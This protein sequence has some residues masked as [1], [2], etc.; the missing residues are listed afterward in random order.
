M[1]KKLAF[2]AGVLFL[3]PLISFAAQTYYDSIVGCGIQTIPQFIKALLSI[4]IKI[5][6]PIASVFLIWTGF[7]FLTAQGDESKLTKAKSA[8]F[9][10]CIGFGVVIGA[11]LIS[12]VMQG[13]ITSFTGGQSQDASIGPCGESGNQ[14][15][16]NQ[17]G[18]IQQ[19]I[20]TLPPVNNNFVV[21]N[22]VGALCDVKNSM[23][24]PAQGLLSDPMTAYNLSPTDPN[25]FKKSLGVLEYNANKYTTEQSYVFVEFGGGS[26][27]DGTLL[28]TQTGNSMGVE[29]PT[30]KTINTY[31]LDPLLSPPHSIDIMH[32]HP[33]AF[34][35]GVKMDTPPSLTDII[36]TSFYNNS[37]IYP[38]TTIVPVNW[39]VA[40]ANGV[41]KYSIMPGSK[42]DTA[43]VDSQNLLEKLQ[44]I[45]EVK[46]LNLNMS[47]CNS[48]QIIESLN[49][50]QVDA[51]S[52]ATIDSYISALNVLD[53]LVQQD[54]ALLAAQQAGNTA[55]MQQILSQRLATLQSIGVQ[56]NRVPSVSPYTP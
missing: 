24:A 54:E 46:K 36:A 6:I 15:V 47:F 14:G 55:K 29:I 40:D 35:N 39:Y 10:T 9:W 16:G 48:K 1:K 23:T 28:H 33:L 45:P 31:V 13:I 34:S 42:A 30:P 7:M 27:T 44:N 19:P 43:V 53:P 49:S 8:F 56:V 32:T 2:F 4:A 50:V 17:N 52:K 38:P 3:I 20:A 25:I 22:A 11:W 41:W 12:I 51:E 5:G 18:P 26:P 21:S 37:L